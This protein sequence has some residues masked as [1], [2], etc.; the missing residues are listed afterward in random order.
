MFHRVVSDSESVIENKS[1]NIH[2]GTSHRGTFNFGS[3]GGSDGRSD[4]P[5][6]SDEPLPNPDE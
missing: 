3:N 5:H 6:F 1:V 2:G 4:S